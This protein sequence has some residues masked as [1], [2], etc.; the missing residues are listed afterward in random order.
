[1]TQTTPDVPDTAAPAT[2]PT[3]PTT[4]ARP[5]LGRTLQIVGVAGFIATLLIIAVIWLARG[6]AVGQVDGV[7]SRV[8]GVLLRADTAVTKAADRIDTT[9]QGVGEF[10]D[11]VGNTTSGPVR[12]LIIDAVSTRLSPA[13]DRYREFRSAYGDMRA[14]VVSAIDTLQGIDRFIPAF[15]V[16]QGP[17][18]ALATVDQAVQDL[19]SMVTDLVSLASSG[20]E[21]SEAATR[22][23]SRAQ[24]VQATLTGVSG[25]V[26]SVSGTIDGL[27]ADAADLG[28]TASQILTISA[29]ALTLLTAYVLALHIALWVLGHRLRT[30]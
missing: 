3:A 15:S 14:Q 9:A 20:G 4:A 2:E 22:L 8:D 19:D 23:A 27:R 16:P 10:A 1:M 24:D 12:S 29:L 26:R 18:D 25:E 13:A 5:R 6:W 17:I 11:T 21:T 7:V 30:S 28:S